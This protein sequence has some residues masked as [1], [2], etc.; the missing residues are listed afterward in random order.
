VNQDYY[1]AIDS[2]TCANL[3]EWLDGFKADLKKEK[4]LVFKN[5]PKKDRVEIKKHID[6]VKLLL[7]YAGK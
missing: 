5:D 2:I 4:P 3:R 1:E 7:R 6:A